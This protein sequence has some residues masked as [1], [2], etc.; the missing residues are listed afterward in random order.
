MAT[1]DIND[2]EELLWGTF[3]QPVHCLCK[4]LEKEVVREADEELSPSPPLPEEDVSD[5]LDPK[6]RVLGF[7]ALVFL[8]L[9]VLALAFLMG[10]YAV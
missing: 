7:V 8:S 4:K 10:Q 5:E 6:K 9:L 3:S 2:R 1:C